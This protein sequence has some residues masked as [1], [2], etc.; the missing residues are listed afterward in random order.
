MNWNWNGNGNWNWTRRHVLEMC[1]TGIVLGYVGSRSIDP[2]VAQDDSWRQFGYDSTNTGHNPD[3]RGV[4]TEPDERWQYDP[5]I[6]GEIRAPVVLNGEVYCSVRNRLVALDADDGSELWTYE[7]DSATLSPPAVDTN[8][9][10]VGASDDR[11]VA[12]EAESGNETWEFETTGSIV[13]PPTLADDTVYANGTSGIHAIDVTDGSERWHLENPGTSVI[14]VTDDLVAITSG[15]SVVLVVSQQERE[16]VTERVRESLATAFGREIDDDVTFE[17]VSTFDGRVALEIPLFLW[18]E[19]GPPMI[20]DGSLYVG[21]IGMVKISTDGGDGWY[22]DEPLAVPTSPTRIDGTLFFG[23]G[24]EIEDVLDE[25]RDNAGTVYALDTDDGSIDWTFDTGG[26]INTSPVAT[27][28][29]VYVT[30]DDG[31]VY[32]LNHFTGNEL[33]RHRVGDGVGSPIVVN[34]RLY[35]GSRENG[36]VALEEATEETPTPTPEPTPTPDE[37]DDE[38]TD[39]PEEDPTEPADDTGDGTT[40]GGDDRFGPGLSVPGALAGLGGVTY[41]LKRRLGRDD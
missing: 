25:H 21:S 11:I 41:L 6:D 10:Y 40:E 5:P 7:R 16:T 2:V 12:V 8:H 20:D 15:D 36:L 28:S 37:Q 30:S 24:T 27:D 1:G 31:Y 3:A 35:V 4:E 19:N 29:T 32:A 18:L 9:V 38:E 23:T 22:F 17:T 33:W 14:A 26:P 34:D 39:E 13:E